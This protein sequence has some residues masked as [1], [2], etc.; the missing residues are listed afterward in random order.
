LIIKFYSFIQFYFDKV[1]LILWSGRSIY[2]LTRVGSGWI[3]QS[4]FIFFSIS[5][6]NI[7]FAT[8]WASIFFFILFYTRLSHSHLIFV[9]LSNKIFQHLFFFFNFIFQHFIDWGLVFMFFFPTFLSIRLSQSF[10]HGH[11]VTG[12]TRFDLCF[13]LFFFLFFFWF[14]LSLFFYSYYLN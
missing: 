12:L 1:T 13:F 6:F 10:T 3:F 8:N 2:M 14:R 7:L 5:S 9:L 4:F 11:R